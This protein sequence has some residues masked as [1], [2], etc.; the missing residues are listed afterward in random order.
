MNLTTA[1]TGLQTAQRAIEL[2]GTNVSNV[3]TEGY[4]RQDPV[5]E[6]YAGDALRGVPIAGAQIT[7]YRRSADSLLEREM[8]HQNPQYAQVS[9]E[10]AALKSLQ[11]AFGSLDAGLTEV[12]DS[13]FGS[14]REL[15]A[16]PT[17]HALREQ[18]VWAGQAVGDGFSHLGR[19]VAALGDQAAAEAGLLAGELN[20]LADE[21]AELNGQIQTVMLR[22]GNANLLMDRRDQAILD[23]SSLAEVQAVPRRDG[24]G[25]VDVLVWQTPVVNG[26]TARDLAV[27][28]VAEG[29][30]GVG[31]AQTNIRE[32][33]HR[34]GKLGA[35]LSLHNELLAGV[36]DE[37]DTLATAVAGEINRLHAQG[38]GATGPHEHLTGWR[39]VD[40]NDAIATWSDTVTAGT[41]HLRLT[42][43]DGTVTRHQVAVD[44]ATDTLADVAAA[45]DAL[46]PAGLSASVAEGSLVIEAADGWGFDFLPAPEVSAAGWTGSAGPTAHGV[47]E[48]SANETFTFTA[49]GDGQVG[50][51]DGLG[52]EVRNGAGELVRTLAV[53]TGYAAGERLDVRD[54]LTVA[55]AAGTLVDGESFTVEARAWSDTSGLLAEAGV[56]TFFQGTTAATLQ[57]APALLSDS[58]GL[59]TAFGEEMVDNAATRRMAGLA[60]RNLAALNEQSTSDAFRLIVTNLGQSVSLREARRD[61]YEKIIQQLENL[62][63]EVSGVDLN[64][65]AAKLMMFEQMYTGLAKLLQVQQQTLQTLIDVL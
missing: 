11:S 54:G 22:G 16:D 14:L 53:G 25:I 9:R 29:T 52:V 21:V 6:P 13:F 15:A 7:G 51:T 3:A 5:I 20:N 65:E 28:R 64:E 18:A 56:N 4:H 55:L 62:R 57:V 17:S 43:P 61:G 44:P 58:R 38:V 27:Q 30:L 59:A 41:I 24:S 35:M 48:G 32:S 46:N 60:E 36:G 26:N 47:F 34:G 10:L 39:S 63:E 2:V 31:P 37:L 42:A 23:M 50:V 45:M 19:S 12:L 33:H 1:L 40:E 8:R 49:V